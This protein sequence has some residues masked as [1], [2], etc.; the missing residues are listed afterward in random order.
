MICLGINIETTYWDYIKGNADYNCLAFLGAQPGDGPGDEE[1]RIKL[2]NGSFWT[3][4]NCKDK[5][6]AICMK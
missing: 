4:W 2:R 5:L 6:S 1:M 3:D